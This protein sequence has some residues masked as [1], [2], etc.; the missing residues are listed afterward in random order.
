MVITVDCEV[1][2]TKQI[3]VDDKYEFLIKKHD[4]KTKPELYALIDKE[5]NMQAELEEEIYC[6]F[7][8]NN[9][10]RNIRIV[11]VYDENEDK[12]FWEE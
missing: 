9:G 10:F 6:N 1:R 11:G 7:S 2:I 4:W 5:K 8:K 3:E 12:V